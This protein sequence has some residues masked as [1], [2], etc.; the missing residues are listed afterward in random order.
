MKEVNLKRFAGPYEEIP[1]KYYI[2]S[3]VGLVPKDGGRETRLIFHLSYPKG[4]NKSV[5]ANILKE[6]CSVTYP[7]FDKAV[8]LCM[9]AGCKCYAA[10]SDM[11]SAFRNLGVS[12]L[13]YWLL[14]LKATSPID[15]KTYFFVDKCVPFGSGISCFLFQF[16]F[17]LCGS[18]YHIQDR[19]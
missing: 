7:T 16:F 18:H 12:K 9:Q 1:F 2:Q 11:K 17:R 14:I 19:Q 8:Q 5:N 6:D 10:I 4:S 13:D 15:G 3:P